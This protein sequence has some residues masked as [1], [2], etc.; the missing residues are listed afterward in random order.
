MYNVKI[1]KNTGYNGINIPDIPERLGAASETLPALD[2]ITDINLDHVK[3][4][5]HVS[6]FFDVDYLQIGNV[7]YKMLE[8]PT[9]IN[10]DTTYIPLTCDGVLTAGGMDEIIFTDGIVKRASVGHDDIGEYCIEDELLAPSEPLELH[11]N[12]IKMNSDV[13]PIENPSY[14]LVEST[15][16]LGLMACMDGSVIYDDD[17]NN[18]VVVP[19]SYPKMGQKT[20]YRLSDDA[21]ETVV[22]DGIDT[23]TTLFAQS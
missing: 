7:Y 1:W 13:G 10:A 4:H 18:S 23:G 19:H 21:S 15:I 12:A 9:A 20:T 14:V 16:D 8:P 2:T 6:D 11:V 3:V 22:H 5:G 17:N